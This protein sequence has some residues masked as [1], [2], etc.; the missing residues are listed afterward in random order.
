MYFRW[1]LTGL[2]PIFQHF[3]LAKLTRFQWYVVQWIEIEN[4]AMQFLDRFAMHGNCFNMLTSADLNNT[5][6]IAEMLDFL[7]LNRRGGEISLAG[8]TNLN[9]R[10]TL[11][12]DEDRREFAE[13]VARLPA[14][15]LAIF[16]RPPYSQWPWAELLTSRPAPLTQPRLQ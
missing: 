1:S 15:Y 12:G 9:P 3:D 4:R 16:E 13:V 10:P 6:R 7:G 2:E 11:V 14:S 8:S 5:R